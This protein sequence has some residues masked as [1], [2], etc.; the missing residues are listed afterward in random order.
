MSKR[1]KGPL[2]A[3]SS[4]ELRTK[5]GRAVK[6]WGFG[7]VGYVFS[8]QQTW[9]G[10]GRGFIGYAVIRHSA[11]GVVACGEVWQTLYSVGGGNA[12]EASVDG[13]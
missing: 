9:P 11:D 7:S 10:Y 8:Q 12:C 2:F 1:S 3:F 6:A 4:A 5:F 13:W